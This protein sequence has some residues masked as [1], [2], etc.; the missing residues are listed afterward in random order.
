MGK[1]TCSNCGAANG[2]DAQWCGLCLVRFAPA[3][4][5][6]LP[7]PAEPEPVEAPSHAFR[8]TPSTTLRRLFARGPLALVEPGG[9]LQATI[10]RQRVVGGAG[11]PADRY[12]CIDP[13]DRVVFHI[14]PYRALDQPAWTVF[15]A[16][17]LPLATMIASSGVVGWAME[18]RDGTGAPVAGLRRGA[19]CFDIVE[20]GGGRIGQVWRSDTFFDTAIEDE[21]GLTIFE[22]PALLPRH[23]VV[24]IPLVCWAVWGRPARPRPQRQMAGGSTALDF[25][26]FFG[27]LLS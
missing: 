4:V 5:E 25:A 20:T 8:R 18:L 26:F 6:A 10:V 24:A 2:E 19:S 12:S 11:E 14:E 9:E 21:W 1:V 23:A 17:G 16:D 3:Q 7:A 27:D 15:Q 13:E 22:E